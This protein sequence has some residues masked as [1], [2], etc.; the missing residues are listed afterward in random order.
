MPFFSRAGSNVRMMLAR[1]CNASKIDG[2]P[3]IGTCGVTSA[4][5]DI[6]HVH[7]RSDPRFSKE[8]TCWW[9]GK[10]GLAIQAGQFL[11]GMTEHIVRR[12]TGHCTTPHVQLAIRGG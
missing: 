4:T 8:L 12:L 9:I 2:A 11:I 10:S 7:T 3:P 6:E 5:A 1:S